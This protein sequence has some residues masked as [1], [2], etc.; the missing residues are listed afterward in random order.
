[1]LWIMVYLESYIHEAH[2]YN[3][4]RKVGK[5]TTMTENVR[6]IK[7]MKVA[8]GCGGVNAIRRPARRGLSQ[9]GYT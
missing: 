3:Q 4:I 9:G 2:Y 8:Y 5:G 6:D 7:Q 1:M